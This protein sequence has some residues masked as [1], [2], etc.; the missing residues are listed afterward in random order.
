MVKMK[1]TLIGQADFGKSVLEAII[2][3]GKDDLV[4]VF[5]PPDIDGKRQDPIVTSSLQN[6]IP[7]F[8]FSRLRDDEPIQVFKNLEPELCVMAFVTDIVPSEMI[9]APSKGT[10]QYHPSLLPRHR[11]PSSINWPIIKGE[12]ETGITIFWPDDGLDTGP[13]LLQKTIPINEEDTL[14]K[15]YF[16]KMFPIGVDAL[17]ESIDL[18]RSG[19]APRMIQDETQATYEGWCRS[20]D[21]IIDWSRSGRD[22]YNL[23][24]GSDPQPGANTTFEGKTISLYQ[25]SFSKTSTNNKPGTISSLDK[26]GLCI[27]VNGGTLKIGRIRSKDYGKIPASEYASKTNLSKNDKFGT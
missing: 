12:T 27:S 21:A 14:G 25:P 26:D 13:I 19:N 1:I 5:A 22:L 11:G 9:N 17:L 16:K 23:I 4:G 3:Q 20:K 24:R 10:I 15:M 2:N 7:L 8:Q 6:S 18:V